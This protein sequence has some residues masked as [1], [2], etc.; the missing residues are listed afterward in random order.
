MKEVL[1]DSSFILTCVR[2]KIDFFEEIKLMGLQII[3][4]KQVITEIAKL[5]K[6]NKSEARA[7]AELALKIIEKNKFRTIGLDGNSVDAGIIQKARANE[8]LIIA[9]LDRRIKSLIHN[10]KLVIRGQKGLEII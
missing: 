10:H 9:T 2:Q 4:P 8:Y 5:A 6:S 3:I 1:L 7:D